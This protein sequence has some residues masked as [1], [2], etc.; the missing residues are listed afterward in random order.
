MIDE[1]PASSDT[2]ARYVSRNLTDSDLGD[3]YERLATAAVQ[4]RRIALRGIDRELAAFIQRD[5]DL[6]RAKLSETGEAEAVS[7]QDRIRQWAPVAFVYLLWISIFSIAQM[8]LSNTVEEKSNR[9]MEVLL[10]SVSPFE[11]MLGKIFGIA[12]TGLTMVG[13]WVL[14]LL[15]AA[16]LLPALAGG[17]LSVNFALILADPVYLGSFLVYFVLGYLL[18]A[19]VL[20]AVGSVCNTI[21]EAQNLQA[22]VMVL[23]FVP[24]FL[25]VPI[26]QDPNGALAVVMSYFPP[27]TP[28]V[29]MNRAAGDIA[30][31]EYLVTTI[32]L[33]LSVYLTAIAAAKIFR[34]GVLLTGKPPSL[35]EM[36]RWIATPVGVVPARREPRATGPVEEREGA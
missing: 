6:A 15:A 5:F 4:E 21:K 30:T 27:T 34:I 7:T 14:C 2:P 22:P 10:S 12:A 18:Y 8:L 3:W 31:W 32:L 25:M 35:P 20:V 16:F 24:L 1:D 19:S 23:L 28:F 13:T 9:L 29:M 36:L 11:L 26:G 17:G 33:L